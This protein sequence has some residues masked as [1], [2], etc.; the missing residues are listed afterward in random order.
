MDI[1]KFT[2][3]TIQDLVTYVTAKKR[4]SS[5]WVDRVLDE[6]LEQLERCGVKAEIRAIQ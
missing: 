1:A 3:A 4:G 2:Q 5:H 6:K